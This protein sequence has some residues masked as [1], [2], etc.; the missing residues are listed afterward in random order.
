MTEFIFH[1]EGNGLVKIS[2]K[3][4][5]YKKKRDSAS[6]VFTKS[7]QTTMGVI[8]IAAVL[9]GMGG[10]AT[11]IASNSTSME[12]E[13]DYVEFNIENKFIKGWLWRSPFLEGDDVNVAAEWRGEYYEIFGMVRPKDNMVALYP[14]CS[15]SKTRHI[16]NAIKWWLI[17][18]ISMQIL[19]S[20]MFSIPD[21]WRVGMES[22]A[23]IIRDDGIWWNI[24]IFIA[25]GIPIAGMAQQWLPF[26]GLAEKVFRKL[27]LPNYKNIDLVK[28]SKG[29]HT[30]QDTPE[31]GVMYFRY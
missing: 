20:I 7:D 24:G 8:A 5:N 12:E 23:S 16:K 19:I 18:S 1:P 22:W 6:F 21:G 13:A 30:D 26:V 15:R 4:S 3:V 17:F 29:R 9:L 25:F 10:Q 11:A 14:H 28:S 2:G 27:E 31:F